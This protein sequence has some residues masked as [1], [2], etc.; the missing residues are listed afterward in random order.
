MSLKHLAV[1]G[2]AVTAL[3]TPA[4]A[5]VAARS[6]ASAQD[7]AF[8]QAAH[9]SNLAE[10][11]AG[12][13][14]ERK[15]TDQEIRRIG[16]RLVHDHKIL[17][18]AVIATAAILGVTLPS[19][20]DA[21]Q[22]ALAARYRAVPSAGFDALYVTTQLSGHRAAM[23]AGKTE[24]ATG[25]DPRARKVAIDAAPVIAAHGKALRAAEQGLTGAGGA[26][27]QPPGGPHSRPPG[28]APV[29]PGR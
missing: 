24:V 1:V 10:I 27:A 12:H 7:A 3:L 6:E 8:L 19:A 28:G 9:Q 25:S 11:A 13:I 21:A 18:S 17:D 5:A 16:A 15:G 23:R 26:Y 22:Q 14:A 20:P 4:S 29:P 2:G